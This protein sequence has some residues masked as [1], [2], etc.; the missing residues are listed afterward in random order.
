MNHLNDPHLVPLRPAMDAPPPCPVCGALEVEVRSVVFPGIHIMAES[1]C[2]SCGAEYFQDLPVGFAVD[3][4]SAIDK[5]SGS[6]LDPKAHLD[7]LQG[8]LARA[9]GAPDHAEIRIER[10]V[11][12]ECKRVVVL[13]SLDFLYGHVLLKLYNAAHYLARYPELGLVLIVP[14]MFRWLVPKGTAEVW[15]VD[16]GL[17]RM[18]GWYPSIDR[19]IQEQLDGYEEVHL[20]RAYAHPEFASID[21]ALFT[22]GSPFPLKEFNTR[23]PHITFVAR[24]DRLW[25]AAPAHKFI[26]KVLGR[27]GPLRPMG[28]FFIGA[29]DRLMRRTMRTIR[30]SMPRATFSVVG[31]GH[32][33]GMAGLAEDLRTTRM[34]EE[35]ERSWVK[36]YAQ[37]QLVVGVHGSNMLLPTAHAAGCI[38]ILPYDRYGNLLQDISVRW[39][40]RMQSFL[41][42]F[43]DEFATPQDI[44]RHAVAMFKEIDNFH[45]TH[46]ES[47]FHA[48]PQH[49]D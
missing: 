31:L 14:R 30:R 2:R 3:H 38:E 23:A 22:G 25:Y 40:D 42:R 15:T 27:M 34:S 8:P 41:Y 18:Q 26:H 11:F 21:I 5:R 33:G 6:I 37:S 48:D 47:G 32:S 19:Y 17:G 35:V 13:N 4:P 46:C 9:Y 39:H 16:L 44:A 28:G 7:W 36:V 45:R 49:H 20:G 10:I 43:V 12:R 29:Q 1:Y 24:E